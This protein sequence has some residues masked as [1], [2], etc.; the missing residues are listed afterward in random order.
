MSGI[1]ELEAAMQAARHAIDTATSETDDD[2]TSDDGSDCTDRGDDSGYCA[3]CC[4]ANRKPNPARQMPCGCFNE[5][6]DNYEYCPL[7]MRQY[8]ETARAL[9]WCACPGDFPCRD[10][11]WPGF[12]R[13]EIV[14]RHEFKFIPGAHEWPEFA[15]TVDEVF[16]TIHGRASACPPDIM[17]RRIMVLSL[18]PHKGVYNRSAWYAVRQPFHP[19]GAPPSED[20]AF[21]TTDGK[22]YLRNVVKRDNMVALVTAQRFRHV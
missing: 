13:E 4:E 8:I 21:V 15:V 16:G 9:P 6:G 14:F 17:R 18:A 11:S 3:C 12:E 10:T 5:P 19:H 20:H 7:A 1:T 22:C 2:Y